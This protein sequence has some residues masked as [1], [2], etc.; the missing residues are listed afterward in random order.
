MHLLSNGLD[1]SV[2]SSFHFSLLIPLLN[3]S[4]SNEGVETIQLT[5]P[6][7]QSRI[8]TAPLMPDKSLCDNS[9]IDAII[10]VFIFSPGIANFLF[11]SFLILPFEFVS[12]L[13]H[14]SLPKSF[15]SNVFSNPEIP[16]FKLFNFCSLR[17]FLY[18]T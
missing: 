6:D 4:L 8:T 2:S 3:S 12:N 11:N 5:P 18:P 13:I 7:L 9:W 16:N 17:S 14:P 15:L 10:L 1:S